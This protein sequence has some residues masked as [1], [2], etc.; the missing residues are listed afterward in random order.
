[1]TTNQR[2]YSS[3]DNGKIIKQVNKDFAHNIKS[4]HFNFGNS[5]TLTQMQKD[6]H[7]NSLS[8]VSYNFKGDAV[9]L[10]SQLDKAKKDDLTLNHFKIGGPTASIKKSTSMV[11]FLAADANQRQS[12]RP[13]LNAEKKAD[14]RSSHWSLGLKAPLKE[15]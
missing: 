2:V 7:Y 10:R 9:K 5:K 11:N 13:S 12:C 4:S 15:S 6:D 8:R 14:L 1:M 3:M